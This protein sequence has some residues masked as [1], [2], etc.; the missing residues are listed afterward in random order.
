MGY[1]SVRGGRLQVVVCAARAGP[2]T[3]DNIAE[4]YFSTRSIAEAEL[5]LLLVFHPR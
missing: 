4:Y 1:A 2:A 5:A 3:E